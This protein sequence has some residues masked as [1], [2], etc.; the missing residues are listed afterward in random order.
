LKR[1]T[2]APAWDRNDHV[3]WSPGWKGKRNCILIWNF[4][5][6]WCVWRLGHQVKEFCIYVHRE[7][8]ISLARKERKALIFWFHWYMSF[9]Q[10]RVCWME[11][12]PA[13]AR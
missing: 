13:K 6:V 10:V 9:L 1:G 5:S 11:I 12:V 7:F 4:G 2:R 3:V 8:R